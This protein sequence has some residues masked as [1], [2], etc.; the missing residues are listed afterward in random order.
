[1]SALFVTEVN[2][3]TNCPLAFADAVNWWMLA[4]F[5]APAVA[6]RAR[7]QRHR[8]ACEKVA[9]SHEQRKSPKPRCLVT[10]FLPA[11]LPVD[12]PAGIILFELFSICQ[13]IILMIV[14]NLLLPSI[15]DNGRSKVVKGTECYEA[16]S[17]K[18]AQP[19]LLK[20]S[21]TPLVRDAK[22]VLL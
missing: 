11:F 2:V 15:W 19:W 5:C 13:R 12:V 17:R 9:S 1:M 3:I 21:F 6:K 7:F 4:M 22:T 16:M 8:I 14:T 18:S 20:K 10:I